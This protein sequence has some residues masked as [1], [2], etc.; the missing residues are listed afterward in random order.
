MSKVLLVNPIFNIPKENYDS[1]ISVGLLCLAS[2][3]DRQGIKV[4]IID[5]ARQKGYLDL[6]GDFKI[7]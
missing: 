2:Y 6:I 4:K 1:S 7:S 3:L 5:G